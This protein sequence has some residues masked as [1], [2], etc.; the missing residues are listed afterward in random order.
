MTSAHL[1]E[2]GIGTTADPNMR[3][4]HK[5]CFVCGR[6][7]PQVPEGWEICEYPENGDNSRFRDYETYEY[8]IQVHDCNEGGS[9]RQRLIK[10]K[11]S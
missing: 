3:R 1:S 7:V 11:K 8:E 4:Q 2:L 5:K 10:R 6:F 9:E